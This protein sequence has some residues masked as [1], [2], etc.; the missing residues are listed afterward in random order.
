M[1]KAPVPGPTPRLPTAAVDGLKWID[2]VLDA[3]PDDEV[4][5]LV[6][7]LSVDPL[8]ADAIHSDRYAT[9]LIARLLELD[10]GRRIV[11]VRGRLQRTE[12][13]EQ[14][15]LHQQLFA[16]LLELETYRRSLQAAALGERAW[17]CS[18]GLPR[19]DCRKRRASLPVCRQAIGSLPGL[20]S[21]V[22]RS[23]S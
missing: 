15:E 10:A 9:S 19:I 2:A 5:R 8:P 23:S 4:R 16:E 12:A 20:Q 6:R 1:R 13:D 3:S 17:S 22:I 21:S 7:E 18:P 11:D 14:V